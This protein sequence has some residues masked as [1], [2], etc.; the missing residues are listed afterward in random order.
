MTIAQ[1]LC[2]IRTKAG[3]PA[4]MWVDMLPTWL[5]NAEFAKRYREA[6]ASGAR[7]AHLSPAQ[8]EAMLLRALDSYGV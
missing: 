3:A 6:R 5:L 2:I 7:F 4:T 1:T 8:Q